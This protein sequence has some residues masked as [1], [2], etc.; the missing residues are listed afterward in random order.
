MRIPALAITSAPHPGID[1]YLV[2]E[3]CCGIALLVILGFVI[4][5]RIS[6]YRY[7]RRLA[8]SIREPTLDRKLK[9]LSDVST[10]ARELVSDVRIEIDTQIKRADEAVSLADISEKEQEGFATIVDRRVRNA[11]EQS[12]KRERRVALGLNIGFFLAGAA[13]SVIVVLFIHPLT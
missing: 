4:R 10:R 12:G 9:E 7:R 6:E 2:I 1:V 11:L 13:V 3:I 8:R 5:I